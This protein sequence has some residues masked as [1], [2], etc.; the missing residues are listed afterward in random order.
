MVAIESKQYRCENCGRTFNDKTGTIFAN[1]RIGLEQLM[2]A[3][4]SL[5]QF[6]VSI[7]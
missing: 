6:N 1:A 2:F 7:R 3:F 5:L 4:Y